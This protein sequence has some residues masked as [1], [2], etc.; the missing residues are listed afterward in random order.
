MEDTTLVRTIDELMGLLAFEYT[1]EGL[2]WPL[3]IEGV[4]ARRSVLPDRNINAVGLADFTEETVDAGIDRVI[5]AYRREG[6]PFSWV[7]GPT[8]R[9]ATLAEHLKAHGFQLDEA[10]RYAGMALRSLD[11]FPTPAAGVDVH[12]V[13][14]RE[15]SQLTDLAVRAFGPPITAEGARF[16]FAT[17]EAAVAAE[18]AVYVAHVPDAP[19]PVG[20]GVA[21]FRPEGDVMWL[22]GAATVPAYRG[23]GVYTALLA[24]RVEDARSKGY[25]AAVIHAMKSTSAPIVQKYG[26]EPVCDID[27]YY[28]PE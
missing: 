14:I 13:P 15:S 6:V 2:L 5:A 19:D 9:P 8:S 21:Y 1:I 11:N 24:Q 26:F 22:N 23:R 25:S 4:K 18:S 27:I 28:I 7:V 12:A 16:A 17:M 20:F 10:Q 3:H